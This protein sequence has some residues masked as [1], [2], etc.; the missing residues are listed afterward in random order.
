MSSVVTVTEPTTLP[1]VSWPYG[2]EQVPDVNEGVLYT[3]CPPSAY[4]PHPA[5][6]SGVLRRVAKT[7]LH[8]AR[9]AP[10]KETPAMLRGNILDCLIISPE[11]FGRRY[12]CVGSFPL[13]GK[14]ICNATR[15]EWRDRVAS[16]AVRGVRVLRDEDMDR[17][18]AELRTMAAEVR[19]SGEYRGLIGSGT[20]V[21]TQLSYWWTDEETGLQCRAKLDWLVTDGETALVADLKSR[22]D[23]GP[24]AVGRE[25]WW[26]C[27]DVQLAHYAAGIRK[28]TGMNS[29][30]IGWLDVEANETMAVGA[31]SSGPGEVEYEA[32]LRRYRIL[33]ERYR[34][35]VAAGKLYGWTRGAVASVRYPAVAYREIEQGTYGLGETP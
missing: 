33:M 14:G 28:I 11:E 13:G 1:V 6:S 21:Y 15:N 10:T 7:P 32:A 4:H 17:S 20:E 8:A 30:D 2:R 3:G 35:T 18:I 9:G 22:Q 26:D 31:Y 34:D 5:L 29:I 19:N 27:G 24:D 12:E 23:A 25:L 16:G